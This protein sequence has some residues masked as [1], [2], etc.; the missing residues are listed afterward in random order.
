[1]WPH[2]A[3]SA[4]GSLLGAQRHPQRLR[5]T[6][7]RRAGTEQFLA[8]Y[9]VHD[10]CLAGTIH[11]RK[12]SRDLLSAWRRLR[13]CYPKATRLYLILDNLSSHRHPM[14]KEFARQHNIRLVAVSHS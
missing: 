2:G 14:L 9:D 8:F 12:T 7:H 3:A 5:A 1:M 13:A 4:A 6:Y 11:K 10:D